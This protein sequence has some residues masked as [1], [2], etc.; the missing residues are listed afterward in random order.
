VVVDDTAEGKGSWE[1]YVSPFIHEL[2]SGAILWR[3]SV[4]LANIRVES[5]LL[6][7]NETYTLRPPEAADFNFEV[8]SDALLG[9]LISPRSPLE[10]PDAVLEVSMRSESAPDHD[11]WRFVSALCLFRLGSVSIRKIAYRAETL[12]SGRNGE[13]WLAKQ[14]QRPL[15]FTLSSTDQEPLAEFIRQVAHLL[16]PKP[17]GQHSEPL[18]NGLKFYFRSLIDATD[19]EERVAQAVATIEGVLTDQAS[20][21]TRRVSQRAA[22]LLQ[23]GGCDAVRVEKDLRDAYGIR[24]AFAHGRELKARERRSLPALRQRVMDYARLVV[25]KD[26][27]LRYLHQ[28]PLERQ[29]LGESLDRSLI[30]LDERERLRQCVEGGL[31]NLVRS[32]AAGPV[33]T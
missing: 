5:E 30:D 2:A 13:S 6:R 22:I 9:Y 7:V 20:E 14:P 21:V 29:A 28:P 10:H 23:F 1:Q 3:L 15:S 24:S 12:L 18:W 25:V 27:E 4:W 8:P 16:P 33:P 26:L 17:L 31:W 32:S 11:V 19:D